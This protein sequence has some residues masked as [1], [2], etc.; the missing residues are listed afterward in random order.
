MSCQGHEFEVGLE[1]TFGIEFHEDAYRLRPISSGVPKGAVKIGLLPKAPGR[2]NKDEQGQ[3]SLEERLRTSRES[4]PQRES[5]LLR[6][7]AHL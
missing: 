2:E 4:A 1:G 5:R 7:K 3:V 6:A